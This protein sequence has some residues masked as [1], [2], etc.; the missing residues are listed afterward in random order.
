MSQRITRAVSSKKKKNV[1]CNYTADS[2]ALDVD[3]SKLS[4]KEILDF[5]IARNKDSV[6]DKFMQTL[7]DRLP[8]EIADCVEADR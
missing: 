4:T 2:A 6:I 7:A 3:C 5:V 8:G 1:N